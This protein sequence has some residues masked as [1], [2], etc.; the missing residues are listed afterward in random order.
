MSETTIP[1]KELM[2]KT[3]QW[4]LGQG[5][6][7]STLG[8]YKATWNRFLSYSA[9]PA[10]SRETAEQ[11]LLQYF[12]VDVHAVG[13]TLD[14]RMCH[15]RRHMNALDEF[16]RTGTVCRRKV[17]GI[18]AIDGDRFEA[19]FSGYLSYCKMQ[20][21]SR[22]WMDN[23]I[24]GLKVFLLAVHSSN[25]RDIE[26]INAETISCFSAAMSSAS[27]ICMNVRRARCQRVGA[28]LRWLYDHK[29]TDLDYSLQL[30][31]FKRTAPQIPQVWSPE[32]IDK[33]LAVIDTASPVGR[34]NY[35]IF[36][37]LARTGLRISDVVGLKFSNI[38]W[39]GNC[40]SLSQQKTG[41]ALSLPLSKELGMAIIS[42][43]QDGRPQS[44]SDFIFLSHNA[45]FQP[46]GE[47]NNFN[48][49]FRKYLRRAGIVAPT[50]KHT[51]VHTF[52][53]SFA[54]N[55]LRKGTP[56]QDVSQIL[57]HGDISVTENYLRVDIEQMRLCS[58]S[59]EGLL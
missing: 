22:S 4:L 50:K 24:A 43:L 53:H 59:L 7:K 44:S 54:T 37:L 47:H 1:I 35:A 32:E 23:T 15:A 3:E 55:M 20:S 25:T 28:Y 21:F 49:E 31:N 48:P 6:K 12:G 29:Y 51:G 13:Q 30:P 38:D 36:L 18:A 5:Y 26:S 39:K 46:L 19:F 27:E 33:I 41:N 57:G 52:R 45:P 9:S 56:V 58:L 17:R 42:Y 8:V 40:V 34:R 11:F 16:F 2:E 14:K 10:Y